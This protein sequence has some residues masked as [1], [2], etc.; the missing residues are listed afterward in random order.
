MCMDMDHG[1][2]LEEDF[3]GT[4]FILTMVNLRYFCDIELEDI[5]LD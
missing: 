4:C 5:K 2:V 3:G 1:A